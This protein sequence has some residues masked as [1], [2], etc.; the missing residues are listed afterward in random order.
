[1]SV[2]AVTATVLAGL[3][4]PI[5]FFPG[6]AR[7]VIW[8]TPFPAMVQAPIEI[9]IGRGAV[10]PLLAAQLAWAVSLLV[11]GRPVLAGA[12]RTLVIQGG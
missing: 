10:L 11:A 9:A 2:Y 5:A 8:A 3:A 6:W 1:M 7:A 4:I 12:V